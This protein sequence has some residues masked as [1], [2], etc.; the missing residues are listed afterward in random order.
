M[1]ELGSLG[2]CVSQDGSAT[3][4]VDAVPAAVTNLEG[5]PPASVLR[6]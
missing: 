6:V 4:T 3:W 1:G 5:M 2:P